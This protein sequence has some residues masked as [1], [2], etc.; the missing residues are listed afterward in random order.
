MRQ[1]PVVILV[2]PSGVGKSTLVELLL[3]KFPIMVDIITYTTRPMRPTETE[4]NPYHFVPNDRFEVLKSKAFFVETAVVHK[5]QYGTPVDQIESAW[6]NQKV[7]L[8]DVD[9]QG[10]RTFKAK[11]P[12]SL[13]IFIHPPSIDVLRNRLLARKGQKHDDIEVRLANAQKEINQASEFDYQLTNENLEN[14]LEEVKKLI[15]VYL[16]NRV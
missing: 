14:C 13:T 8:M 3:K 16:T 11:F 7:V 6:K 1:K 5:N 9:V 12:Q 2:G 4:G 15:E 10:A